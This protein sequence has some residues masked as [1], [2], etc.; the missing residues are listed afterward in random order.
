[1]VWGAQVLADE[2]HKLYFYTFT[3]RGRELPLKAAEAFYYDW[4]NVLLTAMRT[5]CKREGRTGYWAYVQVTERQERLHPHSHLL[6][7]YLPADAMETANSKGHRVFV[8]AWFTAAHWRAGLGERTEISL[9]DNIEAT[10][11]YI[12]KY[13]FKDSMTTVW[14]RKWKRVRYSQKWPRPP[15]MDADYAQPLLTPFH[16]HDAAEQNVEFV[17]ES[18]EIYQIAIHHMANI[19][20]RYSDVDFRN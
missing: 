11:R 10:A 2:G 18:D 3:C 4:T 16:W 14:P 1:M 15:H 9:A 13:L 5:K 8:S 17:C 20:K 6:C 12:A 19:R 7:N